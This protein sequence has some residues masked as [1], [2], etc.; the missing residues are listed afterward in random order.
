MDEEKISIKDDEGAIVIRAD[1]LPEIFA[2]LAAGEIGDRVRFILAFLLYAMEKK[3]WFD[4]FDKTLSKLEDRFKKA[5]S[6]LTAL[7]RRSKF[8]VVENDE[9]DEND[10]TD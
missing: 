6:E 9:N 10:E 7:E 1:G 3:E 5:K 8:K 2:P 4:E